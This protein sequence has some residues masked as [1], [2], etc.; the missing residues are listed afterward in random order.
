MG[1][2]AGNTVFPLLELNP[3]A[4]IYACDFAPSAVGLVRAHPAYAT[5]AGRVH[6]FVADITGGWQAWLATWPILK[7]ALRAAA[8]QRKQQVD[9]W[10]A[11]H[12]A[13]APRCLQPM[14]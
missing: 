6:A 5:T 11:A 14:T 9:G 7:D 13:V 10:M 8:S 2:G 4:S 3:G 12:T 1:C